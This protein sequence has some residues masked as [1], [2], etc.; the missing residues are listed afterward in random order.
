MPGTTAAIS[1]CANSALNASSSLSSRRDRK[2]H[3]AEAGN[4][5]QEMPALRIGHVAHGRQVG[6]DG[7]EIERRAHHQEALRP[8]EAVELD[9]ERAPDIAARAVGADQPAA[10]PRLGPPIA[11]DRNLDA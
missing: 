11:L 2:H 5:Q 7:M 6:N 10:G 3:A 9:P 4:L 8:G 1:D